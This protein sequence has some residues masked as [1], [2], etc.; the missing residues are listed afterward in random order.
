M[1]H[2]RRTALEIERRINR[3]RLMRRS[4]R[5]RHDAAGGV[6]GVSGVS[7]ISC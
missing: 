2:P 4:P 6:S 1:W 7:S 5:E 3:T